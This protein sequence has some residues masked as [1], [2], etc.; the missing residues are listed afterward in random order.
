[1]KS[2]L[3]L[4][5]SLVL[6]IMT[7]HSS[8]NYEKA[9][10]QNIDRGFV[11]IKELMEQPQVRVIPGSYGKAQLSDTIQTSSLG[12]K[13]LCEVW[14]FYTDFSLE[15]EFNQEKLN[16]ERVLK[17]ESL[18]PG[19]SK[20]DSIRW[21][22]MRITG[23]HSIDT[24]RLQYHGFVL[25]YS[26]NTGPSLG[27]VLDRNKSWDSIIVVMDVTSSMLPWLQEASRWL[28]KNYANHRI[29]RFVYY[30]DGDGRPDDQKVP[31]RTGGVHTEKGEN[32]LTY[33]KGIK[34]YL[35]TGLGNGDIPENTLEALIEAQRHAGPGSTIVLL[36]DNYSTPRDTNLIDSLY[37]PV[38]V[39]A[40]G[41]KGV[42]IHPALVNIAYRSRGS[43][44]T[45]FTEIHDFK[46]TKLMAV[47]NAVL[48]AG[49]QQYLIKGNHLR[50]ITCKKDP[51]AMEP[52]N[53]YRW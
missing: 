11:S 38:R 42:D 2:S 13:N 9:F 21:T 24:A 25:I 51:S 15:A 35:V 1:M 45:C 50:C 22:K 39:I 43:L 7:L 23:V 30:N 47:R 48:K 26:S 4:P 17:L 46:D 34:K 52:G 49:G 53:L 5:L 31:G 12:T 16:K 41:T 19:I 3:S 18:I 33:V 36:A 28:A 8:A 40:C 44:H 10:V 14:L 32:Y 27:N 6:T 29:D 20:M 37:L